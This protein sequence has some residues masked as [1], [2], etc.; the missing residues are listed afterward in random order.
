MQ[1]NINTKKA[2]INQNIR[3][4]NV[5]LIDENGN[6]LGEVETRVALAKALEVGLDL[7]EVSAGKKGAPV[8]RIM[9]YGKWKY[10][11]TKRQ[12][13]NVHHR[14]QTKEVKFRPNTG[15][16]DLAYRA[17]HTDKF[18][19]SGNRVKL[20]VRFKG[21]EQEHMYKTGKNL[22]D[23]FLALLTENFIMHGNA[24]AAGNSISLTILPGEN[25]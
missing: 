14:Q 23:K 17:R 10:E 6:N 11:Q 22:L 21:R 8:C 20:I 4:R 18:L 16:N 5:L 13:K 2:N 19:K 12:K 25:K 1:R 9:D 7:V 24:V 3:S 15:D